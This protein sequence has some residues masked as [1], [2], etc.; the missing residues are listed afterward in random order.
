MF[1]FFFAEDQLIVE[2]R[3]V[4]LQDQV[5]KANMTVKKHLFK[6]P[7]PVGSDHFYIKTI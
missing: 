5:G 1:F 7:A 2:W 3:D 4:Y 6:I